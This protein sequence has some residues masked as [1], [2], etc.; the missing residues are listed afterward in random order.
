MLWLACILLLTPFLMVVRPQ[1]AQAAG[2]VS[3][4]TEQALRAALVGG[5]VVTITC[6]GVIPLTSQLEIT[7]DT[8]IDGNFVTLDGQG[9][10]RLIHVGA[11]LT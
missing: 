10:T 8:I 3:E 9:A 2:V 7:Q 4:C 5:G 6:S 1:P 11:V